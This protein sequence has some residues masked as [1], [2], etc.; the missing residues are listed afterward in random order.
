MRAVRGAMTGVPARQ[1]M[2]APLLPRTQL[3]AAGMRVP[4][5][6]DIPALAR[7]MCSAYADTVDD[8]GGTEDDARAEILRTFAGDYGEFLAASSRV[9]SRD[10]ELASAALITR[11]RG[12]PFVAFSMTAAP[13]MRAGLARACLVAAM[14]DLRA[15]GETEIALAVTVANT[16]ATRLYAS[17]GFVVAP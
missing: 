4:D 5:E 12:R 9:V 11:W 2:V 16:P 15:R 3:P 17:L 14:E 7:L 13:A 8:E 10:G 6:R 1:R